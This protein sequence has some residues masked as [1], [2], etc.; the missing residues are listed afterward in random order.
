MIRTK[1]T[2]DFIQGCKKKIFGKN[3]SKYSM[4]TH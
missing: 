1:L 3:L 4:I 2:T